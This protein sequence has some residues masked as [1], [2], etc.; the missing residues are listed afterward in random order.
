MPSVGQ[1]V[2][3]IGQTAYAASPYG[4][5]LIVAPTQFVNLGGSD[6]VSPVMAI[7]KGTGG[8]GLSAQPAVADDVTAVPP[9]MSSGLN[10]IGRLVTILGQLTSTHNPGDRYCWIDDGSALNDGSGQGIKV[11]L[12]EAGNTLPAGTY[13][14]ITGILRCG[15]SSGPEALPIRVL[16][17]RS[18]ADITAVQ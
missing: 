13:Y 4:N 14:K 5:E 6:S 7:N 18:A 1:K 15:T 3:V 8:G 9:R 17:P 10:N 2:A 11:D 12:V 16:W